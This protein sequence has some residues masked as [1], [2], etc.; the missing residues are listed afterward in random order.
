MPSTLEI[1]ET[2]HYPEEVPRTD[3]RDIKSLMECIKELEEEAERLRQVEGKFLAT[4]NAE[5]L[6]PFALDERGIDYVTLKEPIAKP[7]YL[8]NIVELYE[9]SETDEERQMRK[10]LMQWLE[11]DAKLF[12][13]DAEIRIV[14]NTDG[15]KSLAVIGVDFDEFLGFHKLRD[16]ERQL[17]HNIART[18]R[19]LGEVI[20]NHLTE[21]SHSCTSAIVPNCRAMAAK[22]KVNT[23]G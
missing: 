17:E 15:S 3:K 8:S 19:D 9:K 12:N 1:H 5:L 10:Q 20:T 14:E 21:E 23:L 22:G 7:H 18:Q 11:E 13:P 6:K 4:R 16:K 2:P